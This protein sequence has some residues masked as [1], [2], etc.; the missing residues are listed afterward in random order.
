MRYVLLLL[1]LLSSSSCAA[2]TARVG[3]LDWIAG[4]WQASSGGSST[5]EHWM[6]PAGGSM[7]GMSRTVQNDTT[8]SYESMQIV[9]RGDS[10]VFLVQP[11]GQ[12]ATEFTAIELTS[13]AVVFANPQHDFPQRIL[14]RRA[15]ADSLTARIEGMSDG[16]M[17]GFDIQYVRAACQ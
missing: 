14:Y 8:L 12:A 11:S 13:Q 15:G 7:V 3:Q 9:Q 5:Q 4:C 16:Q 1:A 2:Q 10:V 17:Q 6:R